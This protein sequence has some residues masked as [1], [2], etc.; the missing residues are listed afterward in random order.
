[1]SGTMP[2]SYGLEIINLSEAGHDG[3]EFLFFKKQ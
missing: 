1:M 3:G 2:S